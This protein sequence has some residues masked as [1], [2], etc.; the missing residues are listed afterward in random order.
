MLSF[1]RLTLLYISR[2][3]N[4]GPAPA[5]APAPAS[6][7]ANDAEMVEPTPGPSSAPRS[8]RHR[9]RWS[10]RRSLRRT[11]PGFPSS[12]CHRP[13]SE[14]KGRCLWLFNYFNTVSSALY[15]PSRELAIDESMV[16]HKGRCSYLQFMSNKPIRWG[17]KIWVCAES[18][19]GRC[20][21][22]VKK[23][24][25]NASTCVTP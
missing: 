4:F 17:L 1:Q 13:V 11:P 20:T 18:A 22:K 3:F 24:K 8:P 7:P 21:L 9:Q 16:A 23:Q 10:P 2:Y 19:T 5:P 6:A 25:K 14:A 12:S 15:N